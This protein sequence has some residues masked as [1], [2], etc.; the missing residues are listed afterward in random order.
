MR[1][2]WLF[3]QFGWELIKRVRLGRGLDKKIINKTNRYSFLFQECKIEYSFISLF[4]AIESM[5]TDASLLIPREINEAMLGLANDLK[6]KVCK[7]KIQA[8]ALTISKFISSLKNEI[9]SSVNYNTNLIRALI[10]LSNK[11]NKNFSDMTR[12]DLLF[13]LKSLKKPEPVDPLHKWI[14]TYNNHLVTV[15]RFFK[16]LYAPDLP[17]KDRS[18]P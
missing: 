3:H 8:N 18:K 6:D 7:L 11:V 5:I 13:F 10:K 17:A 2:L 12:D 4:L 16:W 14:G 15:S 9:N 1:I